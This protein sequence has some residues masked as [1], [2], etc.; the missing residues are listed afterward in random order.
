MVT[1]VT[2]KKYYVVKDGDRGFW[3]VAVAA[4]GN[5]NDWKAI[6]DAN[7]SVDTHSLKAGM[8]LLIPEQDKKASTGGTSSTAAKDHGKLVTSVTG[9]KYYVV[10]DGDRGFWDVAV[11]A[12][13]NGS[14]WPAIQKANPTINPRTLRPG[15]KIKVPAKPKASALPIIR[16]SSPVRSSGGSAASSEDDRPDFSGRLE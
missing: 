3:D 12:W 7:P 13:G 15:M 1:T 4:Y 10:K 14:L 5:G 2:G 6:R 11:A 16:G 9:N 8:K